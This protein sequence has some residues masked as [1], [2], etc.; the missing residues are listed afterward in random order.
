MG[1]SEN[2]ALEVLEALEFGMALL[3]NGSVLKAD[4]TLISQEA[5]AEMQKRNE[6]NR[7]DWHQIEV[8]DFEKLV[9]SPFIAKTYDEVSDVQE[10][11]GFAGVDE[12][13]TPFYIRTSVFM[14]NETIEFTECDYG[15]LIYNISQN[16]DDLMDDLTAHLEDCFGTTEQVGSIYSPDSE[17]SFLTKLFIKDGYQMKMIFRNGQLSNIK[18]GNKIVSEANVSSKGAELKNSVSARLA[19][20]GFSNIK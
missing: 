17:T 20:G 10:K 7:L 3:T 4:G 18:Q 11:I 13:G 8:S 19:N 14:G 6:S 5:Y 1:K 2:K 15:K 12:E 9:Q 16:R